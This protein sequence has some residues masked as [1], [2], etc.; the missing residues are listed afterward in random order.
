MYNSII[1]FFNLSYCVS[2]FLDYMVQYLVAA[3][4]DL[5]LAVTIN[6]LLFALRSTRNG[7][8]SIMSLVTG[9]SYMDSNAK[10]EEMRLESAQS[11]AK[12]SVMKKWGSD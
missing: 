11:S 3:K 9:K 8:T 6:P 4:G 7:I 1:N 5:L 10:F 2:T 12:E